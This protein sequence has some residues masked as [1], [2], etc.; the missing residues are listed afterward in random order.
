MQQLTPTERLARSPHT[1]IS[2]WEIMRF[3]FLLLLATALVAAASDPAVEAAEQVAEAIAAPEVA[4]GTEITIKHDHTTRE[5]NGDNLPYMGMDYLGMGYDL[6][7][8][9]PHGD[10]DTMVRTAARAA[11]WKRAA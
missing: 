8:G 5:G 9:N 7:K 3:A 2:V 10:P 1:V 4:S 11:L 6:I